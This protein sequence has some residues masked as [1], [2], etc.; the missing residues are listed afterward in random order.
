MS[1][2]IYSSVHC[3]SVRDEDFRPQVVHSES[4]TPEPPKIRQEADLLRTPNSATGNRSAVVVVA[5]TL[6]LIGVGQTA[7]AQAQFLGTAE[8]FDVL[9]G[10][11]VTNTGPSVK[12][13]SVGVSPG[14]AVVG[15]PPGNILPPGTIH[16]ADSAASQPRIASTDG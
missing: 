2:A 9:A 15:F 16:A 14:A 5:L 3:F 10:T 7:D 8:D 6:C 1:S 11:T 4:L 13:G 12:G